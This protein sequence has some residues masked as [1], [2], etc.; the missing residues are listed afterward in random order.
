MINA[1]DMILRSDQG[2]TL[3][4]D[5]S[6]LLEHNPDSIGSTL[7]FKIQPETQEIREADLV[8]EHLKFYLHASIDFPGCVRKIG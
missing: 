6:A 3:Q 1:P 7:F 8:P 4:E 2:N 5:K